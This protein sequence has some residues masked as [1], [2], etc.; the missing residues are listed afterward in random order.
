MISEFYWKPQI[1]QMP[2]KYT[3]IHLSSKVFYYAQEEEYP[4]FRLPC[5]IGCYPETVSKA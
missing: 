4:V 3:H 5:G 2:T 1:D